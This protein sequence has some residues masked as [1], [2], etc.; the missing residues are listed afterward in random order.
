M[1]YVPPMLLHTIWKGISVQSVMVAYAVSAAT[2]LYAMVYVDGWIQ[3]YTLLYLPAFVGIS[4]NN[5]R[6][7]R[8][9]FVQYMQILE[10]GVERVEATRLIEDAKL[11][12]P[13]LSAHVALFHL[14]LTCAG[15][16]AGHGAAHRPRDPHAAQHHVWLPGVHIPRVTETQGA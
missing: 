1:M 11:V 5:E 14:T 9:S 6:D 3:L 12:S 8:I 16:Q 10:A 15:Y 13:Q 7:N 2:L 4:C